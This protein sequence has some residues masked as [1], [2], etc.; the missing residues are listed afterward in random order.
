ML[1]P[2]EL[3]KDW[4][5]QKG[6][7]PTIWEMTNHLVRQYF[8]DKVGDAETASL[9]HKFGGSGESARDLAY[10]LYSI[11]ER[12]KRSQDAQGYNA[13][14]LGWPELVRLA[15]SVPA[16]PAQAQLI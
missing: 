6:T 8:V 2:E 4:E 13:L 3:E 1:K 11:A 10:R 16:G 14:V 9:L 5:P 12:R 7:R 15:Q